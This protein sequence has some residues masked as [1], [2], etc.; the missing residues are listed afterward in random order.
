MSLSL[1]PF[2]KALRTALGIRTAEN[3]IA[4]LAYGV[5]DPNT[6]A[7]V[8]S[9]KNNLLA[10]SGAI[11]ILSANNFIT[12]GSAAALTLAAPT[13]AQ[14]GTN[15]VVQSATGFAHVITA[16]GLLFDGTSTT[17][18]NTA[19]FA[20]FTGAS[21]RLIAYTGTWIVLTKNGVTVA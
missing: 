20:A 8:H 7:V 5:V 14:N 12:L 13:T 1:A 16:T 2:A 21:V 15:I 4:C 10:A 18:K 9:G 11:A 3:D 6:G 19:T 17:G